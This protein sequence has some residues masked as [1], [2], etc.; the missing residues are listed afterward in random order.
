MELIRCLIRRTGLYGEYYKGL[1]YL[2]YEEYEKACRIFLK[3]AERGDPQAQFD[4]GVMFH[5]GMGFDTDYEKAVNWFCEAASQNHAQAENYLGAIYK[6]GIGADQNLEKAQMYFKRAMDHGN[7][8][9]RS[10]HAELLTHG[11]PDEYR[12]E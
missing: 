4:L 3:L 8:N 1:G 7:E 5:N 11:L 6:T 10:S 12:K 9:A 2:Q